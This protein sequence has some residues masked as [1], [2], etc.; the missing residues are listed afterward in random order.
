MNTAD[1]SI[2]LVDYALRRRFFFIDMM[3]DENILQGWL[4]TESRLSQ[5]EKQKTITLFK[6]INEL[7]KVDPSLGENFQIGHTYYFI[8]TI[9]QMNIQWK[10]AIRP[11]LKEY[12]FGD[13]DKLEDYDNL[14][15]QFK[16]ESE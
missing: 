3:P 4:D 9:N 1:R 10:Y 8:E 14:W 15:E 16:Q 7:I 2:A 5:Q 12:F 6:N 13:G 11:L